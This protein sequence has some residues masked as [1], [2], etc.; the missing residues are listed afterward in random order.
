MPVVGVGH[1]LVRALEPTGAADDAAR[2]GCRSSRRDLIVEVGF[3]LVHPPALGVHVEAG[4]LVGEAHALDAPGEAHGPTGGDHGLGRDAVPQVGG[5]ADDV[6]LDQGDFGAEAGRVGRGGVAAR[7]PTDDDHRDGHG[8]SGWV[9][10]RR[11]RR[12]ARR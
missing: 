4:V 12:A 8:L 6:A 9:G 10:R 1:D 5:P 7:A 11:T 3:D 2:P